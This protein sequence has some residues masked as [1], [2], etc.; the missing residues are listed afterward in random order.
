M[1]DLRLVVG[2]SFTDVTEVDAHGDP[3]H[4]EPDEFTVGSAV[5]WPRCGADFD[6]A[7]AVVLRGPRRVLG[8]VLLG[9]GDPPSA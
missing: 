5:A 3:S 6:P 9:G 8:P 2:L 4:D 7:A 1:L